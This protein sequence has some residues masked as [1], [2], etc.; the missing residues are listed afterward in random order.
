MKLRLPSPLGAITVHGDGGA[1]TRLRLGD[2]LSRDDFVHASCTSNL[3]QAVADQIAA[4][5]AGRLHRFDLPL[6]PQGTAFERAVWHRLLDIPYGETI[7]YAEVAEAAGGVA[8]AAGGACGA[9]PIPLIIPC[10]RVVAASGLGG[11]SAPGGTATKL[12][13]LDHERRHHPAPRQ[14]RL[15]GFD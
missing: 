10:H 8:R 11:F 3:E 2:P 12:W 4:Y 9:N 14:P 13:L 15:P 5:F 6:A 7:T 1:I